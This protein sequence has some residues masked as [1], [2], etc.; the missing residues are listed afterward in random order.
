MT[1]ITPDERPMLRVCEDCGG[2]GGANDYDGNWLKCGAC[3]G[4]GYIFLAT[5]PIE[6]SD[7]DTPEDNGFAEAAVTTESGA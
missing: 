5:D 7:L 1:T 2:D 3:D 6:I 4:E